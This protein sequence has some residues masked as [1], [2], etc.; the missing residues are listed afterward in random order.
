MR[1]RENFDDVIWTDECTVQLEPHRKYHFHKEGQPAQLTGRPK[2]LPKVNIW[3]GIKKGATSIVIFTGILTATGYT[4]ILDAAFLPFLATNFRHSHRFQQDND[5][6]HTSKWTREYFEDNGINWF[7]TPASSPDLNPIENVWDTQRV[8]S[9]SSTTKN[10]CNVIKRFWKMSPSMCTK[11]IEHL[12]K[13]TPKVMAV[14][15]G[16]SGY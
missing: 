15:G 16:P 3:G 7:R 14:D 13:V 4:D 8:S 11:Y 5:L 10:Y 12:C 2:H 9:V 6:K 1:S